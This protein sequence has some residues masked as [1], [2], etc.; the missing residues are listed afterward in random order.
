MGTVTP[1]S[2]LRGRTKRARSAGASVAFLA[3]VLA[4]VATGCPCAQT[5]TDISPGLRWWLFSNFGASRVCPEM[6]KRGVALHL[7]DRAPA[8]GRYFPMQCSY[9][10]DDAR[11]TLTVHF[12]GT[13]YAFMSPAKRV[14]F[15]ATASVEYRPD[16]QMAGSDV[17]VWGRLNRIVQG[18][19]F[20]MG[21]VE[22]PIVDVATAMTP[23][24]GVA[25]FFGNQIVAGEL[26]RGFTVLHNEDT[27]DDFALGL[28]MPPQRPHHPFDVSQ[29]E[30][31]TFANETIDV[32][33]QQRDY[34]GPFEIA[35]PGQSLFVTLTLQG[36]NAVDVMVVDKSV[37][38]GWREAYQTGQPLG[39]PP[40]PVLA[41]GPLNPGMQDIRRF[42]LN[43]GFYY[44]VIDN[45][46]NAGLVAPPAASIFNP[47][48]TGTTARISYLA[49]VGE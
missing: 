9:N 21:Y 10:V 13:G 40:G 47:L 18:P 17:Y 41:G 19:D 45:T 32:Q 7:S 8:I 11:Q 39:P 34:L 23:L 35:E 42:P 43:P 38:D 6:L 46:A 48:G 30:R 20:R 27:G 12:A 3:L 25:N 1:T 33:P 22:N 26:T 28:L 31:F 29:S 24:G 15:S 36:G 2:K 16:F 5:L 49:Q 14:G 37:G 44:V 4:V